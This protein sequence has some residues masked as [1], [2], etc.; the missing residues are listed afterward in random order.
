[1]AVGTSGKRLLAAIQ[2]EI[3]T[4]TKALVKGKEKTNRIINIYIYIID[5]LYDILI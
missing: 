5:R 2:E 4:Q 1:M 3:S